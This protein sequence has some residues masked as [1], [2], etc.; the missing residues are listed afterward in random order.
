MYHTV[1]V[2]H[3]CLQMLCNWR[4]L[5][6]LVVSTGAN[7]AAEGLSPGGVMPSDALFAPVLHEVLQLLT[8]LLLGVMQT[9][10]P[11]MSSSSG[12]GGTCRTSSQSSTSFSTAASTSTATAVPAPAQPPSYLRAQSALQQQLLSCPA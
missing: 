6:G 12:G 4:E 1:A 3:T 11:G 7:G 9:P 10:Q 5:Q 2:S 8:H